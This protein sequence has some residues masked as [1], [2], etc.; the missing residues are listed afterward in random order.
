MCSLTSAFAKSLSALPAFSAFSAFSRSTIGIGEG[1]NE[2][3]DRIATLSSNQRVPICPCILGV[4]LNVI[5]IYCN[6]QQKH[7]K[8]SDY[9]GGFKMAH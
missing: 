7:F 2:V 6:F 3:K 1:L 9:C 5:I 8:F 4:L